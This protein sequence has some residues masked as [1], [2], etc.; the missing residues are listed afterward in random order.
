M[1]AAHPLVFVVLASA[2]TLICFSAV[3]ATTLILTFA[4]GAL[5]ASCVLVFLALAQ[6]DVLSLKIPASPLKPPSI[7]HPR[8]L[9][10]AR[11]AI[12]LLSNALFVGVAATLSASGTAS[13][14]D[15]L[16]AAPPATALGVV[17]FLAICLTTGVFEEG[18]FRGV[19]S[20]G[21]SDALRREKSKH[22]E[23][24]GAL[25][26]AAIFG[27]LHTVGAPGS[28]LAG[29]VAVVQLAL[30]AVQAFLFGFVMSAVL[31]STGSLWPGIALHVGFDVIS[32]GPAFLVT[33][34]MPTT[35]ATGNPI[36]LAVLLVSVVLLVPLAIKAGKILR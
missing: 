29:E 2:V 35:Y 18:L 9:R 23:L 3:P 10:R 22:P 8:T 4:Q 15:A 5:A 36:D 7:A 17:L 16:T 19:M 20:R 33:A 1:R 12:L 6:P 27:L 26:S 14:T 13:G 24:E 32:L 34:Q 30:K 25:I 28:E 21:L 31:S 11:A